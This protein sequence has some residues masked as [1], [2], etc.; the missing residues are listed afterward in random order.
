M[1]RV[2]VEKIQGFGFLGDSDRPRR[3]RIAPG[4]FGSVQADSELFRWRRSVRSGFG[5][6]RSAWDPS[7]PFG[8]SPI[9]LGSIPAKW[10][11][12][13]PSGWRPMRLDSIQSN[14]MAPN[15][16]GFIRRRWDGS[17]ADGSALPPISAIRA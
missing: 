11:R 13:N 7:N 4:G 14:R 6:S 12:S 1:R 17:A 15:R 8:I 2:G 9:G 5:A 10:T 16:I 3:D